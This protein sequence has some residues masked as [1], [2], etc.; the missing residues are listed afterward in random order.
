MFDIGAIELLIL[1]IVAIIVV[2]PKDL[3]GML[4]GLGRFMGKMRSMAREFQTQFEDAARGTGIDEI[5]KG[6]SDVRSYTSPTRAASK[7]INPLK[8]T[9]EGIKSDVENQSTGS[10][11]AIPASPAQE[12][13]KPA[14]EKS[15]AAPEPAG[16]STATKSGTHKKTDAGNVGADTGKTASVRRP[17]SPAPSGRAPK[18]ASNK[19]A[20][21]VKPKA[22]A[23]VTARATKPTATKPGKGSKGGSTSAASH[24]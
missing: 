13:G 23:K 8:E 15:A 19:T 9:A 16:T 21:G 11:G 12:N 20:E 4:R 5:R 2:G 7:F 24:D 22:K 14:A 6:I 18:A 1:A 10:D 17:K 3:P